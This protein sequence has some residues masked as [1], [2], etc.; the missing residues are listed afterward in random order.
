MR[1]C[2]Q[3]GYEHIQVLD[4]QWYSPCGYDYIDTGEATCIGI[5]TVVDT[6][7]KE[8]KTYIGFAKG[9]YIIFDED[10]IIAGGAHFIK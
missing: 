7:S 5:V 1:M 4:S 6:I 9:D 2:K 8:I 3:K 10:L